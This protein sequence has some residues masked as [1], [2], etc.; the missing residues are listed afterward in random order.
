MRWLSSFLSAVALTFMVAVPSQAA[1]DTWTFENP[2]QQ[3]RYYTLGKELRCPKCDGQSIGDSNAPIANDLRGVIYEKLQAGQTDE[4]IVDF[5]VDRYGEFVLYKPRMEG[6]TLWLWL[7]PFLFVLIGFVVLL[8]VIR[9]SRS[10]GPAV[11]TE[12]SDEERERL[13]QLLGKEHGR[14]KES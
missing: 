8:V 2:E 10:T 11:V 1:I 3:E 7:G 12:L 13:N 14:S 9:R 5:M 4:Q 6:K